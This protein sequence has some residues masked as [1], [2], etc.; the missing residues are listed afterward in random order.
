MMEAPEQPKIERVLVGLDASPDSLAALKAAA[1]LASRHGAKLIGIYVEDLNLIRLAQL[2]FA[3]E[4]VRNTAKQRHIGLADLERQLRVQARKAKRA[5][6]R[7]ANQHG[8][9][10]DFRVARGDVP[11]E[12]MAESEESDWIILGRSGWSKARTLGSTSR[13]LINESEQMVL[14]L[15]RG[16]T[17]ERP[18]VSVYDGSENA[19]RTLAT[20]ALMAHTHG[21]GISV[22]LKGA[23]EQELREL[24][25]EAA[26]ILKGYDIRATYRW[27]KAAGNEKLASAIQQIGCLLVLPSELAGLQGDM[28]I[29]FVNRLQCPVLVVR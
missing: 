10:W 24:Q 6:A 25:N 14:V 2:P 12:V 15:K 1:D 17:L 9:K 19:R 26:G 18:V 28:L 4:V 22:F 13:A 21:V 20:A 5:L 27:H 29:D 3:V 7:T 16:F 8:L 23:D 11:V